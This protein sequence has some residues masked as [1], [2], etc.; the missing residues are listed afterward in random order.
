[1]AEADVQETADYRKKY[2]LDLLIKILEHLTEVGLEL[3]A[4]PED[5]AQKFILAVSFSFYCFYT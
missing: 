2:T 5:Q 1:M 3:A 4:L